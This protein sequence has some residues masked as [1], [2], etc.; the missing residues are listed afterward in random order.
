MAEHQVDAQEHHRPGHHAGVPHR[1]MAEIRPEDLRNLYAKV[2]ARG[3]PAK[4]VHARDIVKQ[5]FVFAALHGEKAQA[6]SV[7]FGRKVNPRRLSLMP[8]SPHKAQLQSAFE[9]TR[10]Y[11]RFDM[12]L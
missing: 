1:L 9:T 11:N 2:K 5:V 10:S 6:I 12:G 4:A 3:A 7:G 8:C